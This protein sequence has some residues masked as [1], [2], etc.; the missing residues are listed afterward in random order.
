MD[1][2]DYLS[3]HCLIFARYLQK[4]PLPLAFRPDRLRPPLLRPLRDGVLDRRAYELC[5]LSELRDRLR[6]GDI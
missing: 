5:V 6:A 2:K 1:K 3:T 4:L